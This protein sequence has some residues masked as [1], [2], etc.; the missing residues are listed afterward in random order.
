[1]SA[2]K[3]ILKGACFQLGDGSNINVWSDLWIPALD[4]KIPKPVH[5][6]ARLRV[7]KVAELKNDSGSGWD[8]DLVRNIFTEET[9]KCILELRWPNFECND[10][11]MWKGLNQR[12][13]SVGSCYET[14]SVDPQ[15]EVAEVWSKIWKLN[16][17]DRLKMFL[18]RVLRDV[19]PT[20]EEI[21][22][23]TGVG[24]ASCAVCGAEEETLFHVFKE[25]PGA[26][27]LAFGSN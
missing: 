8:E 21:V 18:W 23:R 10:K 5:E 4:G 3:W 2:R 19:L 12:S 26:R 9:A 17:H 16:I 25:C 24:Y 15:R 22:R 1:M 11:L 20:R 6:G 13:F 14:N 27:S 7:S